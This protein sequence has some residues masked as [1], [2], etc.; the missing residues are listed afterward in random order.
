M[1]DPLLATPGLIGYYD[2]MYAAVTSSER[3]TDLPSRVGGHV[4]S[5]T[6]AGNRPLLVQRALNGR[7]M[8]RFAGAPS[9]RLVSADDALSSQVDESAAY[10]MYLVLRYRAV[11]GFNAAVM[12]FGTVGA[13]NSY[14]WHGRNA[15]GV[16]RVSRVI[17]GVTSSNV[18]SVDPGEV[19]HVWTVSYTPTLAY[20]WVNGEVSIDGLTNVRAPVLTRTVLG[21]ALGA[22]GYFSACSAD[23]GKWL[24]CTGAHSAEV[25]A[26]VE[27]RLASEYGL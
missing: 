23:I 6:S 21:A 17:T 26:N 10:T 2:P 9:E 3:V 22:G 25:R 13:E 20:D 12:G 1:A 14:L 27:A 15:T 18:G 11:A 16:T 4:I 7:P 24:I 5:Q 19:P 8:I